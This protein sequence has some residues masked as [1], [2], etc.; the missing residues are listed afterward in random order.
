MTI[1]ITITLLERYLDV[2]EDTK[3]F[4]HTLGLPFPKTYKYAER[5][6][7]IEDIVNIEDIPDES[8]ECLVVFEDGY[9]V[10]AMENPD[11]LFIRITDLKNGMLYD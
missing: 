2:D 10:I 5:S 6:Y 1:F 3:E 11:E 9:K 4:Y 7:N 8:K